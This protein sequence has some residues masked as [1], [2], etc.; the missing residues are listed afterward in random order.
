MA[1]SAAVRPQA[2]GRTRAAKGSPIEVSQA[3]KRRSDASRE[4]THQM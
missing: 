4:K 1:I 2:S 3:P